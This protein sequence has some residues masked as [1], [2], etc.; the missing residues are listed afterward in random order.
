MPCLAPV[1]FSVSFVPAAVTADQ[2]GEERVAM[3]GRAVVLAG[4]NVAADHFADGFRPLPAY[5]S[6][7]CIRHQRQ[8]SVRPL[9]R[10]FTPTRSALYPDAVAVLP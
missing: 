9:R 5:V 3:L 8:Q 6:F 2:P 4:G 10:I 7:V 1:Y